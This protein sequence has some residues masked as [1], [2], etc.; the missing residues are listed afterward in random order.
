MFPLG[1][2]SRAAYVR[3]KLKGIYMVLAQIADGVTRSIETV[4]DAVTAPFTETTIRLGV[5]GLSRAGKTVFITS[6]VAN[7]MDRGRMPGLQAHARG[8]IMSA[9]LQPQPDDTIPRF[10]FETHL[11]DLTGPEP[12]W[13]ES[14]RHVS[15][16]RLSIKVRPS[17]L[18]GVVSG[19]RKVHLDIVDYPGE[20]LLDLG[21]LDKPYGVWAAEAI[22]RL[23]TRPSGQT[24]LDLL[25][26]V[27][28]GDALSETT[29]KLLAGTFAAALEAA[30]AAGFSDCSPG[31]FLLPGEL[32][33]SPVLTFAPV[34]DASGAGRGTLGREMARRYEAYKREVV[35]PFFR[36]HFSRIDRQ[37]VLLDVLGAIHNGPAALEDLRRA[38][39]DILGS[40]RA[41]RNAWLSSLL[42]A[43]RVDHILF[44]AT[45]ADH[46]HHTQHPQLT[47]IVEA[48]VRE[49]RDKAAFSGA[50][51]G[52]IALSSLRTTIEEMRA[53]GGTEL[54]VVRGRLLDSGKQA[55]FYPGALPDD[56]AQLLS[57]ARSGRTEWLE[58]DYSVMRFA[59]AHVT[60]TPGE[61]PPH[62]RL[63]RAAEF[64]LGDKLR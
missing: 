58:G 44:A 60:A 30:R 31:R 63:D 11:A 41:G 59:P 40:F 6:L 16:L 17:G 37:I 45:K 3:L 46:L 5:T 56:P 55:A 15:Q 12:K 22:E 47:A 14:T 50:K 43:K 29:A 36:D 28:A 7:L 18:L 38:M 39:A 32:D 13:P 23:K 9:Y 42:G 48:M 24:Y 19:P 4:T 53:H 25:D 61:G 21:L 52:A 8:G 64:L 49:A 35:K 20:W 34:P 27:D 51:A 57:P 1:T 33:G 62:I 10:D 26:T 2:G 54:G